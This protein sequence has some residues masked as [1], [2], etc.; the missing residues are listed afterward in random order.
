MDRTLEEALDDCLGRLE[1]EGLDECFGRYP[2]YRAELEPLLR[3]AQAMN[4][5]VAAAE[6]SPEARAAGRARMLAALHHLPHTNGASSAEPVSPVD[7]P[8]LIA[9]APHPGDGKAAGG[10]V[11]VAPR[12][13]VA[14]GTPRVRPGLL[15]IPAPLR[16]AAVIVLLVLAGLGLSIP[17]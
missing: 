9:P 7:L 6:P 1:Q 11:D 5:T 10:A 14:V 3:L 15:T 8:R 13:L 16:A 12:R 17:V 2:Q 4:R